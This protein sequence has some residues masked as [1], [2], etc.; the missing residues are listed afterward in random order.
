MEE[1]AQ[2]SGKTMD[3]ATLNTSCGV[4]QWENIPDAMDASFFVFTTVNYRNIH[5]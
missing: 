2:F 1:V 4:C 3:L 5:S